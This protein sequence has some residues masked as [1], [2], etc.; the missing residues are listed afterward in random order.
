[1]KLAVSCS[2]SKQIIARRTKQSKNMYRVG[3]RVSFLIWIVA[4]R[5]THWKSRTKHSDSRLHK[6]H[7]THVL[8]AGLRCWC[9]E[10]ITTLNILIFMLLKMLL[11]QKA[12]CNVCWPQLFICQKICPSR[13]MPSLAVPL[14]LVG[15]CPLTLT[16]WQALLTK[17][18]PSDGQGELAE[19]T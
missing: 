5:S 2:C 7:V 19:T 9:M 12:V 8:I 11:V 18:A 16:I 14:S 13:A 10:S 15:W 17:T 4:V 1:M 6:V 3:G